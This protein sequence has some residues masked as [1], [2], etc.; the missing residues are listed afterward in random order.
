MQVQKLCKKLKFH[1]LTFRLRR[2]YNR[3]LDE[4]VENR[5]VHHKLGLMTK[6][7]KA[8]HEWYAVEWSNLYDQYYK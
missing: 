7:R 3:R 1:W 8:I 6:Q 2:E 4:V 5:F